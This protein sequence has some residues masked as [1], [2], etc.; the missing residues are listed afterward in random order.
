[1]ARVL[2]EE[3]EDDD[4]AIM[5]MFFDAFQARKAMVSG[6]Q[7]SAIKP[8]LLISGPRS[9]VGIRIQVIQALITTGSWRRPQRMSQFP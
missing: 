6:L 7:E 5:I 4:D 2:G 3:E 8:N 1:M 9:D